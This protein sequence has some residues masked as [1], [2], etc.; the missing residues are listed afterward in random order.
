MHKV[1]KR[2]AIL[3]S[4]SLSLELA[5]LGACPAFVGSLAVIVNKLQ[6][7]FGSLKCVCALVTRGSRDASR[8]V[9][10]ALTLTL[11]EKGS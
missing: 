4:E 8:P 1:V 2:A 3:M 7:L 6:Q 5:D 9:R 11:S 10:P